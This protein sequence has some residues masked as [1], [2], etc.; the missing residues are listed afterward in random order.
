MPFLN[1][2]ELEQL[3]SRIGYLEE[4]L[5]E[6]RPLMPFLDL[7]KEISGETVRL[8]REKYPD[9][10][11]LFHS[12]SV[13]YDFEEIGEI[14]YENVL[15]RKISAAREE[16]VAEY[17]QKHRKELYEKVVSNLQQSEGQNIAKEVRQKIETD[18]KLAIELRDSARKEL[19]A[20][21]LGVVHTEISEEQQAIVNAEAERQIE[22]DRLDVKFAVERELDLSSDLVRELIEVGDRLEIYS[23]Q[24]KNR[25]NPLV[26]TWTKDANNLEGWTWTGAPA[27]LVLKKDSYDGRWTPYQPTSDQFVTIGVVNKDLEKVKDVTQPDKLVMGLPL[28]IFNASGK[29]LKPK[30]GTNQQS[31]GNRKYYNATD[32]IVDGTDFQ[33]KNLVFTRA[34]RKTS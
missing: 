4:E 29:E 13:G 7:A 2:E 30:I 11:D 6:L 5:E 14:A 10:P 22:L 25:K 17:E 34:D 3:H 27:E 9:D 8:L 31:Y 23:P 24:D 18:P 26:F 32:F 20:R 12:A 21:A 1:K 15:K 16:L 28:V 19:A 33:T